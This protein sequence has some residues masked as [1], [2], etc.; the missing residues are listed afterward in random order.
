MEISNG[1]FRSCSSKEILKHGLV[2]S[3]N[4]KNKALIPLLK[5]DRVMASD[6]FSDTDVSS[7]RSI[8]HYIDGEWTGLHQM[9]I[10]ASSFW[11]ERYSG[12]NIRQDTVNDLQLMGLTLN[13]I[14]AK[15]SEHG[16]N[17]KKA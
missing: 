3:K 6:I 7:M 1:N 9:L 2:P 13:N 12:D 11:G 17:I 8:L 5:S 14:R 15:R 10:G 4:H 16:R